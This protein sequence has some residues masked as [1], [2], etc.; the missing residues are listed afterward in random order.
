VAW[1]PGI[2]GVPLLPGVLAA[3]EC[4]VHRIVPMGDHDILVGEMVHA[5]IHDGAPLLYFGGSY[6]KL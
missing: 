2:T 6:R 5:E 1:R 4:A 3:I